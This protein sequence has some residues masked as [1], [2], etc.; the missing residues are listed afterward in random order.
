VSDL[1]QRVAVAFEGGEDP[2]PA[3]SILDTLHACGI[4][5][6][7]FIDGLWADEC[8]DVVRR[9]AADGHELGNHGYG[10]PDW[11][12]LDDEAL[13]ADLARVD[14]IVASLSG[15]STRP[16]VLPPKSALD[17]RVTAILTAEGYRAVNPYPLDGKGWGDNSTAAI[18]RRAIADVEAGANLL[19]VHTGRTETAEALVHLLAD[20]ERLGVEVTTISAL[21]AEPSYPDRRPTPSAS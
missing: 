1:P 10:H 20:L 12:Q 18:H 21:G 8:P 7:F 15:A 3:H 4:V 14:G 6:T 16:W 17:A 9:I 13:C 5:A 2:G 11:T 19:T